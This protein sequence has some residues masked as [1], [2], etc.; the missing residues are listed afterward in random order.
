MGG[1]VL[2][3]RSVPT[4]AVGGDLPSVVQ[5]RAQ[6]PPGDARV[7]PVVPGD[8][9]G[10]VEGVLEP[11]RSRHTFVSVTVAQRAL[12]I[13]PWDAVGG[14]PPDLGAVSRSTGD[15]RRALLPG[16][17]AQ[18]ETGV[19]P[20]GLDHEGSGPV[21][22]QPRDAAPVQVEPVGSLPCG[23]R[24]HT[25][26][27]EQAAL[28]E[29]LQKS[30]ADTG[31]H[32]PV[33]SCQGAEEIHPSLVQPGLRSCSPTPAIA[34]VPHHRMGSDR[35]TDRGGSAMTREGHHEPEIGGAVVE[36][37]GEPPPLHAGAVP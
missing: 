34:Q 32:H 33:G 7:G 31:V 28:G 37:G 18:P 14:R 35:F 29:L 21:L 26:G 12:D 10:V 23:S 3:S 6:P 25:V 36:V 30:L 22:A 24:K 1:R 17:D 2:L 13:E 5:V 9:P 19:L 16:D 27:P 20:I 8:G 15:L 4:H 11:A